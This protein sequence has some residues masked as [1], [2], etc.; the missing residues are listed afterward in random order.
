VRVVAV[1]DVEVRLERWWETRPGINVIY[2]EYPRLA[3]YWF[4]GRLG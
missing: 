2:N 3:Y 1:P 4:L